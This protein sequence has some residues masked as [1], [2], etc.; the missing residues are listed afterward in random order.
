MSLSRKHFNLCSIAIPSE[1]LYVLASTRCQFN[2][3]LYTLRPLLWGHRTKVITTVSI[4][5]HY[6]DLTLSVYKRGEES[7]SALIC[8]ILSVILGFLL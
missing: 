3:L 6:T 4:S 7:S 2:T 1:G 5:L 8:A